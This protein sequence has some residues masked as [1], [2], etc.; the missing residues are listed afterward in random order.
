MRAAVRVGVAVVIVTVLAGACSSSSSK[1][2]A[3]ARVAPRSAAELEARVL[4]KGPAGFVRQAEDVGDT[5]PSDL[6]KAARDEGTAN[7]EELLRSEGFVRGYQ[8]LWIGPSHE[9]LI[10]FV[11]QFGSP[12]GVRHFFARQTKDLATKPLRGAHKFPV[13]FLPPAQAVGIAGANA[14]SAAAVIRLRSGVFVVQVICNDSTL[15][16]LQSRALAVA[17]SQYRRL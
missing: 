11:Y 7:A 17:E 3:V 9:Q 12:A 4:S 13:A 8:R 5:G 15:P 2:T 6:A 14:D 1:P 16:G 10:V